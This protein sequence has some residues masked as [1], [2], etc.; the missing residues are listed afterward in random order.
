LFDKKE[1]T[2]MLAFTR[3]VRLAGIALLLIASYSASARTQESNPDQSIRR[4]ISVAWDNLTRSTGDCKSY[5]DSK[6]TSKPTLYLPT[7]FIADANFKA[8]EKRCQ[9]NVLRLRHVLGRLDDVPVSSLGQSGLLYLPKPYIVPGGRF[10][11]MYGW[12]SYFIE[13]GLLA[14]G[15]LDLAKGMLE[16]FLFEVEHYSGVRNANSSP[17]IVADQALSSVR[18][19]TPDGQD[20]NAIKTEGGSLCRTDFGI[21]LVDVPALILGGEFDPVTPP[22][23]GRS[24]LKT[25]PNARFVLVPGL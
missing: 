10:N 4:Y 12:D 3:N 24:L 2:N 21:W 1:E 8:F 15:R 5:E 16:N 14:D 13:M 18:Q 19:K 9:V 6:V 23:W 22:A 11:E 25:M 17:C 7:D 20:N